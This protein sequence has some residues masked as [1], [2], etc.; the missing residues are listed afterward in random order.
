VYL[1]NPALT[2]SEF[3]KTLSRRFDLGQD[4][5]ASKADLLEALEQLLNERRAEGRITALVIDEAQSLSSELL[6]EVRLLANI[7]T[8]TEKLLPVVLAGQPELR[9]RLNEPGLRQLKQRVTLRCELEPFTL[10]ETACYIMQRVRTAGGDATRLFS[11]EAVI[12]I[13]ERSRG[14][15]RIIN[16]VCDNALLTGC[17]LGRQKVDR[18][19]VLEVAGDFDLARETRAVDPDDSHPSPEPVPA[20]REALSEPDAGNPRDIFAAG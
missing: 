15:P 9:Q 7:E 4:A 14:I 2:R 11:R 16:V 19:V 10:H 12:A 13:Y 1:N 3:V 18:E 6:E 20:L 17:G 5:G 8:A